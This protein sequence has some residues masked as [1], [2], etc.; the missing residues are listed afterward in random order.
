[1]T[2]AEQ[3]KAARGTMPRAEIARRTGIPLRTLD[4]WENNLR[5]PKPYSLPTILD[6]I[7]AA[8]EPRP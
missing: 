4:A 6:T 2:P 5:T 7:R 3:I 1:M 8:T